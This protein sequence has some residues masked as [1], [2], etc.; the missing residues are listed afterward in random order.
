MEHQCNQNISSIGATIHDLVIE[1]IH[2]ASDIYFSDDM[3]KFP[4]YAVIEQSVKEDFVLNVYE[5]L[6]EL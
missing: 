3:C 2:N 6:F 1:V 5:H 4:L